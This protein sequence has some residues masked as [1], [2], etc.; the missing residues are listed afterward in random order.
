MSASILEIDDNKLETPFK[1]CLND[2]ND[3]LG[4]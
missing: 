4:K 1:K 2:V 3:L